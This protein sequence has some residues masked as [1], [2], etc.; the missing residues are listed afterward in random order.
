[1]SYL[2]LYRQWRPQAFKEVVGQKS[3]VT[4]LVNAVRDGKLAHAYLFSGPRG[5]GKTSVAK[6]LAKAVNCSNQIDGEPCNHCPAC[7]DIKIG[8]FMDV[9]EIDAASNRGIDE[10]RD[11]REKVRVLPAQGKKK[12]YIIDEVHM[13]TTEAFN[14][15][16]KTLEEPPDSVMFI[17]ATTEQHKI[18]ATVL[19]RCQRYSFGRLSGDEIKQR[20]REVTSEHDVNISDQALD[21]IVRR[22]NGGLRDALST[23]D[24]CISYQGQ[25]I[26]AVHVEEMLGLIDQD[27]LVALLKCLFNNQVGDI[28]TCLDTLVKQGKEPVQIAR[29]TSVAIRDLLVYM[30]LGSESEAMILSPDILPGLVEAL[31]GLNASMLSRAIKIMIDLAAELRFN[32]GQRFLMEAGFLELAHEFSARDEKPALTEKVQVKK[33]KTTASSPVK[34]ESVQSSDWNNILTSVKAL[35]PTTYALLVPAAL[36]SLDED[37]ITLGYKPEMNFHREKMGDKG[38]QGILKAATKEVLGSE[39]EINLVSLEGKTERPPVISKAVEVF[40]PD[41]VKIIE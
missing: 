3:T 39:R 27:A 29:D 16:L 10:I 37:Q 36:I 17:L 19:S 9:I 24:Q 25:S 40:G 35:R 2:A 20:L 30:V 28:I 26:E 1:M 41:K 11:L 15:L 32:E 13:L 7:E 21:I 34:Q 8:S 23:L 38:N 12:V 6:I 14:A 18:P 22:A 31:P 5:T 4:G 33:T